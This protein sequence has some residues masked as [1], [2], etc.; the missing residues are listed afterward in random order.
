M[1]YPLTVQPWQLDAQ[2]CPLCSEPPL[3]V[4]AD[5]GLHFLKILQTSCL[6]PEAA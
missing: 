5:A 6:F 2:A 4:R 3:T 1:P